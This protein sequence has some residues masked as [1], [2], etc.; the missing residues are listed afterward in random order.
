MQKI[1]SGSGA[2]LPNKTAISWPSLVA[3]GRVLLSVIFVVSGFNKILQFSSMTEVIA[4]QGLPVPG[5][6][7]TVAMVLEIVGG[8]SLLTGTFARFGA[9]LPLVFLIPVT[10]IMHDFW[11][12]EGAARQTQMANFLKNIALMGAM[13]MVVGAGA[14][15][16]SVDR[17]VQER[18]SRPPPPQ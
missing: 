3:V 10:F 15:A 1:L 8:L 17:R 7:L 18:I 11:T 14:G 12:F 4:G 13:F 5:L 16:A 6:F 9:V 2:A